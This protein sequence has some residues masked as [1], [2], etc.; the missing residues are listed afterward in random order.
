MLDLTKRR[1]GDVTVI[2]LQGV[3]DG[4]DSCRAIHRT[5]REELEAGGQKFVVDLTGVE[6]IN[7]LGIG[8]LVAAS[9]AAG[10]EGAAI[11]LVGMSSRVGA[12]LRACGVVPHMWREAASED[13]AITSLA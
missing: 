5:F 4:G 7:S 8:F 3:I 10:K 1:V 2:S 9:I 13:E 11:R 6:W 12:A